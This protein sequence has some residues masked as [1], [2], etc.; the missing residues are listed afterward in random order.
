[1]LNDQFG[2]AGFVTYWRMATEQ[3]HLLS[4]AI[5]Y[6]LTGLGLNISSN[7]D[8][9]L[10]TTFGGP[11]ADYPCRPQDMDARVPVEYL[12]NATIRDKLPNIR[13]HKLGEDVLFFL[14]YNCPGES[15]PYAKL[16]S[17]EDT[18]N[19]LWRAPPTTGDEEEK[20][21]WYPKCLIVDKDKLLEHQLYRFERNIF[22]DCTTNPFYKNAQAGDKE[23]LAVKVEKCGKA[24]DVDW[25]FCLDIVEVDL[26]KFEKTILRAPTADASKGAD[27]PPLYIRV[28]VL[29]A[30]VVGGII[31]IIMAVRFW[32][33]V[34][35]AR[36]VF[37]VHITEIIQKAEADDRRTAGTFKWGTAL[38][39]EI[40]WSNGWADPLDD[41]HEERMTAYN[42]PIRRVSRFMLWPL[43]TKAGA[44]RAD[45]EDSD[46]AAA[47][48]DALAQWAPKASTPASAPA[49]TPE[50]APAATP[51]S[52][53]A[54]T[55]ESAPAAET[56]VTPSAAAT[57]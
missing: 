35:V 46:A 10:Y 53:P 49:A 20:T 1:M 11:W 55:P 52:A 4:M 50:S 30:V 23:K 43:S 41:D 3:Q 2:M 57:V 48:Q 9:L 28:T 14:F 56:P 37:A 38:D 12:T 36:Q 39:R 17:T 47:M 24:D 34:L 33:A 18:I 13:L 32:E 54:A 51:E 26:A 29:T 31:F 25:N 16:L 45:V 44:E 15:P 7:S 19:M 21:F 22:L 40:G 8:R 6:D 42:K 27:G 5:G